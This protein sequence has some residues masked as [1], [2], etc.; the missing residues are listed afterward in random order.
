LRG[1]QTDTSIENIEEIA[2]KHYQGI[3]KNW[4]S[5]N[6]KQTEAEEIFLEEENKNRCSFCKNSYYDQAFTTLIGEE[7]KICS[8][9]VNEFYEIINGKN[10]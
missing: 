8:F 1:V 10:P 7:S 6:Y 4:I 3:C 9:C 5:T 2:E